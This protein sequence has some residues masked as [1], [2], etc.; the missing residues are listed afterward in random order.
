MTSTL[1]TLLI[2]QYMKLFGKITLVDKSKKSRYF[3]N[4][5][6]E[7]LCC[8]LRDLQQLNDYNKNL[9]IF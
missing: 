3:F 8:F 7:K 1:F 4:F 5:G 6:R 9:L 2:T